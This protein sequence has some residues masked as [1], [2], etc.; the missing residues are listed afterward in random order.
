MS[1]TLNI[2]PLKPDPFPIEGEAKNWTW[3]QWFRRQDDRLFSA[4]RLD[5]S[6]EDVRDACDRTFGWKAVGVVPP[7]DTDLFGSICL[8]GIWLPRGSRSED[9]RL[10]GLGASH[11][12]THRGFA[13]V[14]WVFVLPALYQRFAERQLRDQDGESESDRCGNCEYEFKEDE[15]PCSNCLQCA[16]CCWGVYGEIECREGE[17]KWYGIR[18]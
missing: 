17:E 8:V 10:Q 5:L 18:L 16:H 9:V 3:R 1:F 2:E 14:G 15:V 4:P 12:T 13:N 7:L 11:S 6:R